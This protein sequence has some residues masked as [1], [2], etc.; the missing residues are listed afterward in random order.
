MFSS[1]KMC[2]FIWDNQ[3][4]SKVYLRKLEDSL[5]F[6]LFILSDDLLHLMRDVKE[7]AINWRTGLHMLN[8]E[9]VECERLVKCGNAIVISVDRIDWSITGREYSI[10]SRFDT[11]MH[12]DSWTGIWMKE[13]YF[14]VTGRRN[15]NC[16]D[17]QYAIDVGIVL[18]W[19]V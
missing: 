7:I 3:K 6:L 2:Q 11:C 17:A 15:V 19:F 9:R 18:F 4:C 8:I 5:V 16:E 10:F 13:I 1:Q 12:T 14:D